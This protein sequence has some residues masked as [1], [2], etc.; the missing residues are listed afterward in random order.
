[1]QTQ[2][3]LIEQIKAVQYEDLKLCKLKEDI[4]NRKES[5]FFLDQSGILRCGNC[6]CVPDVSDLR[7]TMLEEVHNSRYTIHPGSTKMYQ[8]L[9]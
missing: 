3:S 6:L 7:G 8:D 4:R 2:S 1:M 9:K 5:E